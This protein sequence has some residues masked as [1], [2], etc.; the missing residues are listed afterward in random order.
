MITLNHQSI[1]NLF[2]NK[3]LQILAEEGGIFK[4]KEYISIQ[5]S[6]KS[7]T[8]GDVL[9]QAYRSLISN[10]RNEYVYKNAIAEKIVKGRHKLANIAFFTEFRVRRTIADVVLVNGHS[11]VYEIKTEFDSFARLKH[12][13]QSYKQAFEYVNVVIPESKLDKLKKEID[14]NIGI[15]VLTEHYTLE[16]IRSSEIHTNLLQKD[17]VFDCLNKS[18]I[19]DIVLRHFGELPNAKP[20]FLRSEC[21]KAFETLSKEVISLEFKNA[22]KHRSVLASQKPILSKFPNSLLSLVCTSNFSEENY[23]MMLH[24]LSQRI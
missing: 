23:G 16:K 21:K 15:I 4:L 22:L 3:S 2:S 7:L 9:E 14:E 13:L 12:Q 17:V 18:E 11:S 8:L 6:E 5:P 20:A 1:T 24:N 19:F 10:Y